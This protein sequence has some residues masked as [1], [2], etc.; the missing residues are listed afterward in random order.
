[1]LFNLLFYLLFSWR[2]LLSKDME[3]RPVRVVGSFDHSRE[4][5]IR[6]RQA[7]QFEDD[8]DELHPEKYGAHVYTAFTIK[9][10]G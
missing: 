3:Y 9:D 5:H 1:M 6:P 7:I 10:T 8:A 2:Q 4:L